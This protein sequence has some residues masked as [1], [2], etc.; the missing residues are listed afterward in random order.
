MRHWPSL[1]YA[2]HMMG[3]VALLP[4]YAR[5]I[6]HAGPV[7]LGLL[8]SDPPL[9]ADPVLL[10]PQASAKAH[11]PNILVLTKANTRSTVH[12]ITHLDYVGVKMFDAT[13]KVIGEL[14]EV[15]RRRRGHR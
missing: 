9:G 15:R 7:G 2:A 3:A 4:I 12:R 6:L 14:M 13:G 11:E 1:P 8:R 5:D 10:T